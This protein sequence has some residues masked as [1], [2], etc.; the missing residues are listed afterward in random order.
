MLNAGRSATVVLQHFSF[1]ERLSGLYGNDCV[2]GNIADC[3]RSGRP[4]VTTAADDRHIVFQHL[5]DRRLTAASTGRQY[6]IHPQIV[7]N[8]LRQNIQP[9]CAYQLY[10]GQIHTC[11]HRTARTDW[12]RRHLHFRRPN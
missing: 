7:R 6:G 5:H 9:I 8:R 4:C 10:F 11:R 12:C 1:I 3:P 2:T